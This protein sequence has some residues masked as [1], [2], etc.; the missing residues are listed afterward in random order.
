MYYVFTLFQKPVFPPT[1]LFILIYFH[2]LGFPGGAVVKNPPA[3][4]G[5][6]RDVGSVPELEMEEEMTTHSSILAWKLSWTEQPGGLLSMGSQR[7]RHDWETW[8]HIS[9]IVSHAVSYHRY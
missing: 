1:M 3:N 4:A 5:D 6:A 7:V 8:A 9:H 2:I